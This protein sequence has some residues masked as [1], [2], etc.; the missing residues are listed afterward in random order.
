MSRSDKD[1]TKAQLIAELREIRRRLADSTSAASPP[2]DAPDGEQL[3]PI[4]AASSR[5]SG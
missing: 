2:Q 1:K 4:I 5:T 3:D